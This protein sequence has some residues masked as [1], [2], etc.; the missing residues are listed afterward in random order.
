ML[1]VMTCMGLIGLSLSGLWM[2]WRRRDTGGLGAP[3]PGIAPR[4][5]WS[6]LAVIAFLAVCVPLFG[7]TVFATWGLE[8]FVL[9]HVPGVNTWLVL[10]VP[11]RAATE[12]SA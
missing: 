7:I 10:R 3:R 11:D 2:W 1:G 6:L 5:S 8:R 4:W 9:R 12:V